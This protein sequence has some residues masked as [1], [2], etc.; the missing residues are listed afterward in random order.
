MEDGGAVGGSPSPPPPGPPPPKSRT[1]EERV[2][3]LERRVEMLTYAWRTTSDE[4]TKIR[5]DALRC[6]GE[7]RH[8]NA[9]LM[10]EVQRAYAPRPPQP[11]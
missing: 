10:A 4:N 11:Y 9:E 6:L 1:L 8:M 2:A 3:R 5:E 7:I